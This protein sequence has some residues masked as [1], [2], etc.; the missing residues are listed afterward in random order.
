MIWLKCKK[1]PIETWKFYQKNSSLNIY[2][3]L[4]EKQKV[5][6]NLHKH[7][8]F[9]VAERLLIFNQGGRQKNKS[10]MILQTWS[11]I[12]YNIELILY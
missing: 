5:A 4:D 3:S 11:N 8:A 7:N 9:C 6:K 2:T 10:L 12:P 1:S